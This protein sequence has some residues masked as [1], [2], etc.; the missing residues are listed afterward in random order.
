[1]SSYASVVQFGPE[2]LSIKMAVYSRVIP[3]S[4]LSSSVNKLKHSSTDLILHIQYHY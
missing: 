1:M 3:T 2:A 4:F